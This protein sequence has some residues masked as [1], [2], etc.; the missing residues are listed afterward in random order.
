MI[1]GLYD[2]FGV[3]VL[4]VS[5]EPHTTSSAAAAMRTIPTYMCIR[6]I[7][8]MIP[9]I[10]RAVRLRAYSGTDPG[11]PQP[12][13]SNS[14]LLI[15]LSGVFTWTLRAAKK[16][17]RNACNLFVRTGIPQLNVS[18]QIQ[19]RVPGTRIAVKNGLARLHDIHDFDLWHLPGRR[20]PYKCCLRCGGRMLLLLDALWGTAVYLA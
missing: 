11:L 4:V 6:Y 17:K 18:N 16:Q 14:L 1:Q 3:E 12:N 7:I 9:G 13:V 5:I 19:N 15:N 20:K 8:R 2:S 10:L